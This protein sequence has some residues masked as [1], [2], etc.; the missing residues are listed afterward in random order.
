VLTINQVLWLK[1]SSLTGSP[2]HPPS[3]CS[4]TQASTSASASGGDLRLA[5]P[6]P[7][8]REKTPP[9]PRR[10]QTDYAN[11]EYNTILPLA[12]HLGY[13][14]TG[15]VS[16]QI[17][18][19][20]GNDDP[21]RAPMPPTVLSSLQSQRNVSRAHTS[22]PPRRLGH[23]AGHGAT[24]LGFNSAESVALLQGSGLGAAPSTTLLQDSSTSPP[25]TLVHSYTPTCT[26][27]SPPCT[28]KRRCPGPS[29]GKLLEAL[30]LFR[31]F[32]PDN[33]TTIEYST[34]YAFT[35]HMAHTTPTKNTSVQ[36]FSPQH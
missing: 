29:Q 3:R 24:E 31:F 6:R 32:R 36:I 14:G 2:I 19:V 10:P 7:R 18:P 11:R 27:G 21:Q 34:P 15:P 22:R 1:F 20:T 16:H 4:Q 12:S 9:R 33:F 8:L 26:A 13:E 5:R 17:T 25:S 35:T 28:Y 23:I 30:K